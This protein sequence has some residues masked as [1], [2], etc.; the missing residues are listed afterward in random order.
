MTAE[1]LID[2]FR[3]HLEGPK[4]DEEVIEAVCWYIAYQQAEMFLETITAKELAHSIQ[5]GEQLPGPYE[6][7]EDI[8]A[9]IKESEEL[10]EGDAKQVEALWSSIDDELNLWF[11]G[12]E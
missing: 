2:K 4:T 11:G 3:P 5:D 10:Y 6:T 9:W 12:R 8:S 1:T 7:V